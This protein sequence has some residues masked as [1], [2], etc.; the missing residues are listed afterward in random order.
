MPHVQCK[1][2]EIVTAANR[3]ATDGLSTIAKIFS[4]ERLF[5]RRLTLLYTVCALAA[6]RRTRKKYNLCSCKKVSVIVFMEGNVDYSKTY[7]T[8]SK[9]IIKIF[10]LVL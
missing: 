3:V 5:N 7:C 8:E 9:T 4:L 6:A 10:E 2:A 1:D